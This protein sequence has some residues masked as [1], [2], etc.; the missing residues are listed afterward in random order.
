MPWSRAAARERP[1]SRGITVGGMALEAGLPCVGQRAGR[2]T[3]GLSPARRGR[4]R[5]VPEAGDAQ[6]SHRNGTVVVNG[7][8]RL[9]ARGWANLALTSIMATPCSRRSRALAVVRGRPQESPSEYTRHRNARLRPKSPGD[10]R[11]RS[12][13]CQGGDKAKLSS[14]RCMNG[15]LTPIPFSLPIKPRAD[16]ANHS[17]IAGPS[18]DLLKNP[19]K[20]P[21]RAASQSIHTDLPILRGHRHHPERPNCR[22]QS[23]VVRPPRK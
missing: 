19:L 14:A 13:A 18:S 20:A 2:A 3:Q 7:S 15:R 9:M 8:T 6:A 12:R 21:C 16:W 17:W 23:S 22:A 1:R 10:V 4:Y 5:T 11:R